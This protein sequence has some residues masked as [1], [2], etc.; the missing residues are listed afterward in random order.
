MCIKCARTFHEEDAARSC[1]ADFRINE[2]NIE[3]NKEMV[4]VLCTKIIG[5]IL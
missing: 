3:I 1:N 5:T 4:Q 2:K